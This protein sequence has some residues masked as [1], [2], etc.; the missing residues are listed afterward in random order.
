MLQCCLSCPYGHG[1]AEETDRGLSRHLKFLG[2]RVLGLQTRPNSWSLGSTG[3]QRYG[4]SPQSAANNS[5]QIPQKSG[6]PNP[7]FWRVFLGREHFGTRPCQSPSH[8]GI[9]LHFSC[10][11]L[12]SPKIRTYLR[13]TPPKTKTNMYKFVPPSTRP[14]TQIRTRTWETPQ[15]RTCC[16]SWVAFL[17]LESWNPPAISCSFLCAPPKTASFCMK[18][19]F[20][21]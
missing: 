16:E 12:P 2:L 5:G 18:R 15:R 13:E 1:W 17:I 19:H 10:P 21:Q 14:Y 9:R 20:L 3:V 7:L 4:C 6:A 11:H 8:F